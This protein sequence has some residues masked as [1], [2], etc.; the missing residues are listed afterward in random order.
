MT[1]PSTRGIPTAPE[2]TV[3]AEFLGRGFRAPFAF[4]PATGGIAISAGVEN[5]EDCMIAIL[6]TRPGERALLP[7]FGCRAHD[8]L[9]APHTPSNERRIAHH[10]REALARWEPRVEVTHV[11]V[12]PRD[13]GVVHVVV[14]YR[15]TSTAELQRLELALLG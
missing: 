2:A 9:F 11:A 6:G 3:S 13:S 5:V 10:V 14:S 12:E 4:D 7:E 1:V 8:L 15:I